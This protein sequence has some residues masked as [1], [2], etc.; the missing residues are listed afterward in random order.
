[1]RRLSTTLVV[2]VLLVVGCGGDGGDSAA[3]LDKSEP[4][5]LVWFSDSMGFGVAEAWA[6]LIEDAEGVEVRVH[7]YA[8][9][10]TPI[11]KF[12]QMLGDDED[13]RPEVADA[14]IIVVFGNASAM[15]PPDT[16]VCH[17]PLST[18][19]DPPEF[20]TSADFSAYGDVYRGIFEMIFELR[21][22]EPTVIRVFDKFAGLLVDWRE[23]GIDA[24]CTATY[25]A[26]AGAI[27]EAADEYGVSMASVYDAF[28]GP[29]HDQDPR[30]KGYV[31]WDGMH[32]SPEGASAHAEVLHAL[33]YAAIIP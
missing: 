30:E 26:E 5:D 23:A 18:D 1:M 7:D 10:G 33:G 4:W 14:E 29:D 20:Y 17:V 28:N 16:E 9:G 24:E 3:Q 15:G 32:A 8:I 19:R 12:R 13:I 25:E 2:L 21:A 11:V 31:T 22:G 6:E 27:R